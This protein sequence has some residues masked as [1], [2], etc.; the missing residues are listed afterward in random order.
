[1]NEESSQG[2][3]SPDTPNHLTPAQKRLW[4]EMRPHRATP[5]GRRTSRRQAIN[6]AVLSFQFWCDFD[7]VGPDPPGEDAIRA[8]FEAA[9]VPELCPP[10]DYWEHLRLNPGYPWILAPGADLRHWDLKLFGRPNVYR[11]EKRPQDGG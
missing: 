3:V 8:E 9:G 11:M 7:G 1:V 10:G 5:S 6:L 2:S 4:D